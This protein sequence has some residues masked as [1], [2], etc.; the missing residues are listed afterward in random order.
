VYIFVPKSPPFE[1]VVKALI[2]CRRF[3]VLSVCWGRNSRRDWEYGT[4]RENAD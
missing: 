2:N 3:K 1:V 4:V